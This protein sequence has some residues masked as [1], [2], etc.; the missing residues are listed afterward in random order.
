MYKFETS[1][2][3]FYIILSKVCS[4]TINRERPVFFVDLTNGRVVKVPMKYA[5]DFLQVMENRH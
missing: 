3:T 2:T 4:F 5:D 1:D